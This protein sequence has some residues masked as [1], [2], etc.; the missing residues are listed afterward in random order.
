MILLKKRATSALAAALVAFAAPAF[1]HHGWSDYDAD[2]PLTLN[3]TI[4]T[5]S[6]E[7]PHATIA[8][9]VSGKVYTV[10]LAP[11]SRMEGRGAAREAVAVGKQI[12]VVGYP[13]KTHAGEVRAER[14]M[15]KDAGADKTVEL[16]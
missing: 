9:D 13:S 14:I 7:N 6:Y 3:G 12:T 1:A 10:I 16:R 2:K 4:K 11:V 5:S 8:L 15:F